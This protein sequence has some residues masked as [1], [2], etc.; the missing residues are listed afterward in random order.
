MDGAPPVITEG[1]SR[2]RAA[3]AQKDADQIRK[4]RWAHLGTIWA[5]K[6]QKRAGNKKEDTGVAHVSS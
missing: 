2:Q 4:G 6:W 5:P 1:T 3:G